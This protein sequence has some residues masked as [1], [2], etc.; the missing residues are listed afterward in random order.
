MDRRVQ[1]TAYL[2]FGF[3]VVCDQ[4]ERHADSLL[5]DATEK[6][7]SHADHLVLE[8][9]RDL[10]FF[11]PSESVRVSFSSLERTSPELAS[12]GLDWHAARHKRILPHLD[13][14]LLIHAVIQSG[15]SAVTALSV[16]GEFAPPSSLFRRFDEALFTRRVLDAA[17][18]KFLQSVVSLLQER[19]DD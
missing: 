4:L 8:V 9:D 10:A 16:V 2:N 12:M 15:P 1:H 6:A 5:R 11:E 19:L 3:Q 17:V 14:T 7:T 13:A 18:H